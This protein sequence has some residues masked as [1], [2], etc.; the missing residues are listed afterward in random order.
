MWHAE[1]PPAAT[2]S[3]RPNRGLT[4]YVF[5]NRS[6]RGRSAS[7]WRELGCGARIGGA[8]AAAAGRWRAPAA[9]CS[10]ICSWAT[11][12]CMLAHGV[13]LKKKSSNDKND[14]LPIPGDDELSQE[15]ENPFM[16]NLL[17]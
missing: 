11:I 2:D 10:A 16:H 13:S 5:I 9:G 12:N 6:K 7:S 1:P 14:S 3:D 15:V 8:A 4:S 17:C